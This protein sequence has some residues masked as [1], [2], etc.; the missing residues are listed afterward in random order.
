VI[1]VLDLRGGRAVHARGGQREEYEPV[2]STL[3]APAG[4]AVALARTYRDVLGCTECYLADLDA[5][6]G[7]EPQRGLVRAITAAG[8]RWLVDAACTTSHRA[9]EIVGAGAA[10]V[11]VGLETLS[12]FAALESVCRAVGA[13][14]VV[15][16][17]DLFHGAPRIRAG[18]ANPGSPLDLARAASDTGVGAL[19]ILDL[20]RVGS[21]AGLD[22]AL[23][24]RLRTAHPAIELLAG[25]GIRGEQDLEHAA[26]AGLDGVLVATALHDGRIGAA[27]I[28]ALGRGT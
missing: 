18:A 15:F 17:L 14:R 20:A 10:R 19:L 2:R 8:G 25:G 6:D 5:I 22:L 1:P 7:D 21:G 3:A 28:Q 27:H 26:Q 16:G 13:D 12:G 23:A 24:R 9:R 4:D 11:V